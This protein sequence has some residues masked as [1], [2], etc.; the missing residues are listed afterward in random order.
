MSTRPVIGMSMEYDAQGTYFSKYPWYA[1]RENY[2][3]AIHQ[4]G[5]VPLLLPYNFE[6][7]DTYLSLVSGLLIPGGDF[8]VPPHLYGATTCHPT[9]KTIPT[10]TNFEYAL[11]K[12]ALSQNKPILGICGGHQL[13][14]VVLGGTLIQHIPDEFETDLIHIQKTPRHEPCHQVQVTPNTL[15]YSLAGETLYEV[16]SIH[17]Q[18]VATVGPGV[19]INA[20]GSDN[21]IEGIEHPGYK[22]CM[23]VQWHP[24]FHVTKSD[25]ALFQGLIK[26]ASV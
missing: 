2:C 6:A 15:L 8:D 24:E 10:R 25:T 3:E 5:G 22:F 20:H 9:V 7:I 23:G 4:A 19:V 17:H 16:N 1:I 11:V 14:N 12:K 21:L 26:A 13:L 18:A